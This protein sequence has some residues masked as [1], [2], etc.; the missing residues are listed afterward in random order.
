MIAEKP[1]KEGN[2][3]GR[4]RFKPQGNQDGEEKEE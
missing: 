2:E 1:I 3:R 4:E